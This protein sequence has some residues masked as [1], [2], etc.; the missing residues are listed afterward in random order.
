MCLALPSLPLTC[1]AARV[2]TP[3][4]QIKV[5]SD[6][7]RWLT[8]GYCLSVV[9]SRR[10]DDVS[11]RRL[12]QPA[13]WPAP[14]VAQRRAYSTLRFLAVI[15]RAENSSQVEQFYKGKYAEL[16]QILGDFEA[17]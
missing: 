9:K 14:R 13:H 3:V 17:R 2:Y 16:D 11:Y 7:G 8:K 1:C 15:L 4:S 10:C 6:R 5:Q 12:P